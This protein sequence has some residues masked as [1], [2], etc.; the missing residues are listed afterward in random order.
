MN[1]VVNASMNEVV[2]DVFLS[3]TPLNLRKSPA[4]VDYFSTSKWSYT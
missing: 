1:E 4:M 3:P 2:N